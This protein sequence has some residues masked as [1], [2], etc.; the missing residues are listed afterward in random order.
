MAYNK[1][2]PAIKRTGGP[3]PRNRYGVRYDSIS[4]QQRR[5]LLEYPIISER[6]QSDQFLHIIFEMCRY[7]RSDKDS[8][9]YYDWSRGEFSHLEELKDSYKT[10]EWKCALS[11]MPIESKIDDFSAKNFVHPKYHDTLGGAVDNRIL[12]SS[13]AFRKHVKKIL[14]KEQKD[15]MKLAK[16]NSNSKL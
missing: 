2:Y 1:K 13:I 3:Y 4:K 9:Y 14:L 12:K 15:F 11:D 6:A 16:K 7:H 10:I 5:L 8:K